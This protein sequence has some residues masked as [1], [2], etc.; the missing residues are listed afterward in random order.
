M[1]SIKKSIMI[2]LTECGHG[3]KRKRYSDA[4]SMGF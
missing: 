1:E 4:F 3:P 2:P